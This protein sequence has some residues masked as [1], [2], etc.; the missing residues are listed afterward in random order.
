M[1]SGAQAEWPEGSHVSITAEAGCVG[2]GSG[3]R[4]APVSAITASRVVARSAAGP[5]RRNRRLLGALPPLPKK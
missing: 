4:D 3:F 1:P 2:I 5:Y